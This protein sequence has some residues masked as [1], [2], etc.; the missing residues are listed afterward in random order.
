MILCL[1]NIHLPFTAEYKSWTQFVCYSFLL[2]LQLNCQNSE[3]YIL[4]SAYQ[5]ANETMCNVVRWEK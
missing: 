1:Y 4:N 2:K 3:F 5:P